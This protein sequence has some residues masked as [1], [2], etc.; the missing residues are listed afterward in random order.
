MEF[1]YLV[2]YLFLAHHVHSVWIDSYCFNHYREWSL[3][4][5]PLYTS[6]LS[7]VE[8][9]PTHRCSQHNIQDNL[10]RIL[11]YLE[12]QETI[13][14]CTDLLY[15]NRSDERPDEPPRNH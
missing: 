8:A 14:E 4:C 11:D 12:I 2:F 3:K 1:L 6:S 10:N 15:E 9:S 5:C 13:V 7:C